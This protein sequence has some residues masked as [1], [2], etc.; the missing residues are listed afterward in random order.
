MRTGFIDDLRNC[1]QCGSLEHEND[2]RDDLCPNCYYD[3]GRFKEER[4]KT[5]ADNKWLNKWQKL[6]EWLEEIK[7]SS[8]K[9]MKEARINTDYY[10]RASVQN[11]AVERVL[12][13]MQ[14]L[15]GED[16]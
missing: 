4:E 5:K 8:E 11:L 16:E 2:L 13:K 9:Q 10:T 14:E 15:E 1:K 7:T 6:K 3:V 12:N